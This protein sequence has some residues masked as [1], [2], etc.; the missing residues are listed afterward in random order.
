MALK[1]SVLC[2]IQIH[3]C[4]MAQLIDSSMLQ[5]KL[6]TEIPSSHMKNMH[7]WMLINRTYTGEIPGGTFLR[8]SGELQNEI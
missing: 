3:S 1:L 5:T 7:L 8:N 4:F 2:M 6:A